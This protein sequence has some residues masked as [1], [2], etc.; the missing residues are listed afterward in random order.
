MTRNEFWHLQFK[1]INTVD[2][3][4]EQ[5]RTVAC[6]TIPELEINTI[7]PIIDGKLS[8]WSFSRYYYYGVVYKS[9]ESILPHLP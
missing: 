1:H 9:I 7:T 5:I 2:T 6:A 4:D 3:K 8:E